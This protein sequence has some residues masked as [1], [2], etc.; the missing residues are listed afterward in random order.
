M[1]ILTVNTADISGGAAR[2]A[3]RLHLALL[4]EGLDSQML[5]QK[6][7]SDN[8]TIIGPPDNFR[9]ATAKI[10]PFL[11]SIPVR[12]YKSKSKALFSPSWI[13]TLGLVDRINALNPDVVHLHWIAGG[14]LSIE[15]LAK[16]RVPI[17]WSLH[18]M[19]AFTGGCHYD[20]S[21]GKYQA[22]CGN[23]PVLGSNKEKDLSRKVWL[24]KK[25]S[26]SR[27]GNIT[28]VGL[29]K[30]LTDC[31][32]SS[33]LMKDKRVVTLPNPIDV[34]DFAPFDKNQARELLNLP[35]EKNLIAFGAMNATGDP[36]K[37]FAELS[38]ALERLPSDCELVVFGSS[39][40]Q[41]PQGFRQKSH[42]LGNLHDDVSLR[43]VYCAADAV[44]VPSRQENLANISME[45]AACGKP[46]VA[47]SVG[48]NADLIDHFKTGYL[49]VPFDTKDLAHGINWVL[50]HDQPELLAKAARDKVLREFDSRIVAKKYIKLY[51]SAITDK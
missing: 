51:Q 12:R 30:W 33:A 5:V 29:S 9:K 6:K 10:R 38:R 4:A 28:V 13:P 25:E 36:R 18:D 34:Q 32:S 22:N 48:G 42:Y 49:A 35:Q 40:P 44:V 19:W 20:D 8:F 24:R 27:L 26:F 47:F 21:C 23:C 31:A 39:R 3:N 37:G 11:D 46:L 14:M 15:D 45:A 1:K 7:N 2:A 50:S 41:T 16:I 17:V 43:L